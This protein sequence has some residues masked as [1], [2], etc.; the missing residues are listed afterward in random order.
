[1]DENKLEDYIFYIAKSIAIL[2]NLFSVADKY[3]TITKVNVNIYEAVIKD[4]VDCMKIKQNKGKLILNAFEG[5]LLTL[6][7]KYIHQKNKVYLLKLWMLLYFH[8]NVT[9]CINQEY[10]Y[11][12]TI[13]H[14]LPCLITLFFPFDNVDDCFTK[15]ASIRGSSLGISISNYFIASGLNF[16]NIKLDNK[17]FIILNIFISILI[18]KRYKNTDM[19]TGIMGSTL[20]NYAF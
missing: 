17:K 7:I 11:I 15:W 4:I 6:L 2:G 14:N 12:P 20:I 8:W 3:S 19:I 1:M 13:A 16:K 9:Y 10:V 18:M 5:I